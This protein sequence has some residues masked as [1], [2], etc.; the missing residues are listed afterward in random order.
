MLWLKLPDDNGAGTV[1]RLLFWG[2]RPGWDKVVCGRCARPELPFR[3]SRCHLR[4]S[5]AMT[6]PETTPAEYEELSPW[7]PDHR[8]LDERE[9]AVV[10]VARSPGHA[11]GS[12]TERGWP[13]WP[14][15]VIFLAAASGDAFPRP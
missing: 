9:R 4:R 7:R 15:A 2:G 10:G 5:Q 12:P 11:S 3:D 8:Q 14:R 6:G 13:G 1:N